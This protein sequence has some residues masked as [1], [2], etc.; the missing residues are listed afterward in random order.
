MSKHPISG[1]NAA[2]IHDAV[3]EPGY[4]TLVSPEKVNSPGRPHLALAVWSSLQFTLLCAVLLVTMGC[5]DTVK[6]DDG[7]PGDIGQGDAVK[8][9]DLSSGDG[10]GSGNIGQE[11][12]PTSGKGCTGAATCLKVTDKVGVCSLPNCTLEDISTPATEDTCP[13]TKVGQDSGK[14]WPTVCTRV[15]NAGG[16][17]CLPKCDIK[18]NEKPRTNPCLRFHKGLACDPVS[19]T[20]N[21]HSEVCLFPRCTKDTDCGN[22]DPLKPDSWCDQETG[23]CFPVGKAKAGVGAPCKVS[24]DCGKNQYCYPERKSS[25]GKV[26]VE[27][28]YCTVVGCAYGAPWTCPS[29]SKCFSMGS[30]NA[31][32]L[33]LA[34]GC[35]ADDPPAKDNCRDEA[36]AGQY[37]C[38]YLDKYQVCWLAPIKSK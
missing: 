4:P 23:L 34:L 7:G 11:C 24:S 32:S 18:T 13:T 19:L 15:P 20:Y 22:K 28:G 31:L 33:C 27:G 2:S 12:D 16:N 35:N 21:D 8:P 30:L 10:G 5:A 6:V 37:D 14:G 25:G 26:L 9:P 36:S 38:I 3:L 1:S 17:F 29:G